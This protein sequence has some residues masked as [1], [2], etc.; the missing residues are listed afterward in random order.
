MHG[1]AGQ[2]GAGKPM[3][4]ALA[5][6]DPDAVRRGSANLAAHIE[7]VARFGVPVVVAINCFPADTDS[8][9]AAVRDAALAAGAQDAVVT[10]Q[11]SDGG[12]GAEDLARAV[13]T[14]AEHGAPGF[15]LLYPDEMP[16]A[17]KI[18]TIATTVYGADGIDISPAA[19]RGL[20]LAEDLGLGRLPVCMAK[21][22][23]SLSHDPRLLGRPRGF[24]VPV[25]DVQLR[26]G[27][28]FVTPLAGDMLTMPGLPS[29]PAGEKID[30]DANGDPY[31]LF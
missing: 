22:Q 11:F 27:A 13:W 16:L 25:R 15:R 29:H 30:L 17:E 5:E 3:D 4:P 21:T 2:I 20:R 19:T 23:A 10:T 31:G 28:G 12:K 26:A 24:R 18:E 6:D 14:A 9:L 8:E 7:N 1:G